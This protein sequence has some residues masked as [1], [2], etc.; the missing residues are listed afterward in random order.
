M[1]RVC[2]EHGV[3]FIND[4]KATNTAS[5]APALAAFPPIEGRPRVHWIVGGLAKEDLAT[6]LI[7]KKAGILNFM[8]EGELITAAAAFASQPIPEGNRV[9]IITNTGGP[10]VIATGFPDRVPA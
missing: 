6:D 1:E 4:S 7:F 5:A 9:G 3:L 10:A 2:E 8:D